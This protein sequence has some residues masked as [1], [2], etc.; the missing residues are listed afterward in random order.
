MLLAIWLAA[1]LAS[2]RLWGTGI[3][4]FGIEDGYQRSMSAKEALDG[5]AMLASAW[6]LVPRMATWEASGGSRP[7]KAGG[8]ALGLT[9]ALGAASNVGVVYLFPWLPNWLAPA[10]DESNGPADF[11]VVD[12]W[13]PTITRISLVDMLL[14]GA[15]A[16][17]AIGLLGRVVG[18]IAWLVAY[19]GLIW[20]Q[21]VESV[22]GRS[23]YGYCLGADFDPGWWQW[24]GAAA[25]WMLAI[26][27]WTR[28]GGNERLT[29]G[30]AL[31]WAGNQVVTRRSRRGHGVPLG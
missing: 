16:F 31:G 21:G 12:S 19:T 28:T 24:A 10:W 13:L 27:V 22:C 26:L 30:R 2:A 18:S 11:W 5:V 4:F 3:S 7:K 9:A 20:L 29:R 23:P 14:M 25:A 8:L 1:A 17:M 6:C 15:L